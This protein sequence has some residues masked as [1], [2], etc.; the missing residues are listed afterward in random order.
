MQT[1]IVSI[2]LVL[3]VK[4]YF[5][6]D[7]LDLKVL[8]GIASDNQRYMCVKGHGSQNLHLIGDNRCVIDISLNREDGGV[9]LSAITYPGIYDKFIKISR[10]ERFHFYSQ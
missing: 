1:T 4:Q 3:T 7:N 2:T 5:D 8:E 10:N 6:I 9:L